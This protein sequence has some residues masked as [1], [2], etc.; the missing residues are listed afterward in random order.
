MKSL[1]IGVLVAIHCLCCF[2][3]SIAIAAQ[4]L[5]RDY[6]KTGRV[7]SEAEITDGKKQGIEKQYY[8]SGALKNQCTYQN[9]QLDG[10]AQEYYESGSTSMLTIYKK[11]AKDGIAKTF[12]YLFYLTFKGKGR[13]R[14]N[15]LRKRQAEKRNALL[16]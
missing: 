6:Y 13:H 1:S 2:F 15:I 9:D 8:E 7:K 11:G 10:T 14:K 16:R 3:C 4:E 5:R 12:Q